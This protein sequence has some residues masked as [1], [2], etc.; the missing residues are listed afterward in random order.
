MFKLI[1]N[2]VFFSLLCFDLDET[3][4][5]HSKKTDK[6][7]VKRF[8]EIL[9]TQKKSGVKIV[10]ASARNKKDTLKAIKKYNLIDPDFIITDLGLYIFNYNAS[11]K[12]LDFKVKIKRKPAYIDWEKCNG[13]GLCTEKC[14]SKVI[15]E[16]N[17]G[18]GNRRAIYIPFPQAVPNKPVIDRDNCL[19]FKTGKCKIC[20]NKGYVRT[21]NAAHIEICKCIINKCG[22]AGK[23]PYLIQKET[24]YEEC[25]CKPMRLR[26]SRI[27]ERF[28][29]AEI[30]HKYKWKFFEDLMVSDKNGKEIPGIKKLYKNIEKV[31]KDYNKERKGLALWSRI[32]GNGK[33]LSNTII[34]N[35]LM[36]EYG[37]TGK[38]VKLSSDYF[39]RLKASYQKNSDLSSLL[40]LKNLIDYDILLIDD[41]G[42]ERGTEWEQEKLYELIDGRN[43]N[44]KLT[45]LTTNID[46]S[47]I[48][49]VSRENRVFSRLMEMCIIC[50]VN[51]PNYRENFLQLN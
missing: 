7:I 11:I 15:S 42:V 36:F 21:K 51:T 46:L 1:P 32:T 27:K 30:P 8:D 9:R 33:T 20:E 10:Y 35:T 29:D 28:E 44:D 18:L 2:F 13:C 22:C 50:H 3:I 25:L 41:F 40:I 14:P 23:S 39:G 48:K 6:K 17:R 26:I 5:D 49:M 37:A 34:L 19:F 45:L 43:N 12:R 38:F 47:N 16:F 31:I 4:I 24:N